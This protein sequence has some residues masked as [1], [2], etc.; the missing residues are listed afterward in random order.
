MNSLS[1]ILSQESILNG[2]KFYES[3]H[4]LFPTI[5]HTYNLEI[6][7]NVLFAVM[8]LQTKMCHLRFQ[9]QI[10]KCVYSSYCLALTFA[11]CKQQ[12]DLID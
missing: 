5:P 1:S 3:R 10:Y 11:S 9:H 12:N 2:L 4:F 6:Q 7:I 8:L